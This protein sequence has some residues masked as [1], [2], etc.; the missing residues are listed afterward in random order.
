[1]TNTIDITPILE[2]VIGLIVTIITSFLIPWIKAKATQE[3]LWILQDIAKIGVNAAEVLYKGSGKGA[4][5]LAYVTTYIKEF[6][7][8]HN[9]SFDDK[10]IRQAIENSWKQMTETE[11]V[12]VK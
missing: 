3:Q 5:K 11:K 10:S 6:C 8:S 1:M 7:L 2:V 12:S 4:E 9:I